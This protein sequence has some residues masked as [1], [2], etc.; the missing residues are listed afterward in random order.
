[1]SETQLDAGTDPKLRL[2]AYISLGN[3][4]LWAVLLLRWATFSAISWTPFAAE[5]AL[6]RWPPITGYLLFGGLMLVDIVVGVGLLWRQSWARWLGIGRAVL[7]ILGSLAYFY[8]TREFYGA[9]FIMAVSGL[10]LVLELR[11]TAWSVAFPAAFWLAVFFVVPMVIVFIVSLGERSRLG[12]VTYPAFDLTNLGVY[13]D[14][15]GR[16]FS[17]IN[18]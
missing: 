18:G 13:F 14:D 15:Y 3:A 12:T 10:L 17:R 1:M 4:F 6:A 7:V 16:F 11:H 2:A 9:A 5:L 8:L